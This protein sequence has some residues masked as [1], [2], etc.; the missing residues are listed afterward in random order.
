MCVAKC[1]EWVVK[2]CG[3]V[4]FQWRGGPIDRNLLHPFFKPLWKDKNDPNQG[5]KEGLLLTHLKEKLCLIIV[6]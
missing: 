4:G 3:V 5:I 6:G 2:G 1:W